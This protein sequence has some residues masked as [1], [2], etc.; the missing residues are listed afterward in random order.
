MSLLRKF[1]SEY[2]NPNI[3]HFNLGLIN[4]EQD[5]DLKTHLIDVF[6]SLDVLEHVEYI[7]CEYIDDARMIDM[8]VYSEHDRDKKYNKAT[9]EE[10]RTIKLHE[11]LVGEL[12]VKLRFTCKGES[13][14]VE[15][16]FLIPIVD[17]YGYFLLNGKRFF[18]IYQLVDSSTYARGQAVVLRSLLPVSLLRIKHRATDVTSAGWDSSLFSISV[19]NRHINIFYFYFAKFGFRA[20]LLY[21]SVNT[22]ID[23]VEERGEDDDPDFLYFTIRA[24]MY[25]RVAKGLF[26][27]FKYVRSMV[28]SILGVMNNRIT[29]DDLENIDYWISRIG[30]LRQGS[31]P[32]NY[33]EKGKVSQA[34]F[35]RMIDLG[36]RK[37]LKLVLFNKD[38]SYSVIRWMVQNYDQLRKKNDMD[39]NN[40]RLRAN[41]LIAGFVSAEFTKRADR[42]IKYKNRVNMRKVESIISMP[43]DIIISKLHNSGLFRSN[44]AVDDMDFFTKLSYTS[45]GPSAMSSSGNT[46]SVKHRGIDTSFIGYIDTNVCGTS[47][48]GA[49]GTLTPF[50]KV[51]DLH[52]NTTREAQDGIMDF[53]QALLVHQSIMGTDKVML[54]DQLGTADSYDEYLDRREKAFIKSNEISFITRTKD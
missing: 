28:S 34:S 51:D 6:M 50:A 45:K 21:F 14:V 40:K 4:R 29:M 39:I 5:E 7:S 26:D 43:G 8:N 30:A 46:M 32:H 22:I 24:N 38:D 10:V 2:E 19:F 27:E 12:R 41:E 36:T 23:V 3:Q 44:E 31:K 49:S 1:L 15:K 18:L 54:L 35:E 53:E 48:P 17:E 42:I 33:H 25:L 47:D 9:D 13:K 37:K 52:F 11:S 20:A 16:R